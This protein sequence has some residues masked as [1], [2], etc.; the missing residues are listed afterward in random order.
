M[1]LGHDLLEPTVDTRA[2]REALSLVGAGYEVTVFCWARRDD[3]L[4][5]EELRDGVR[6]RRI[7]AALNGWLPG[8]M[9]AFRS[10]MRQ[11]AEAAADELP[12]VVH[13]HD[14]ETLPAACRAA[15]ACG[16]KVV[17]DAHED[18]PLLERVQGAALGAWFGW[19]Q[20]RWLPR[21]D[22]VVTVSPELAKR[23]GG[24]EV[25]YNSEPL[26][27]I[28]A[29]AGEDL[30]ATLGLGGVVAGYIGALRRRII[31]QLLDAAA[32]VPEVTLLVVGGPPKGRAGYAGLQ[33]QLETYAAA[34]GAKAVFTG[35][36]GYGRMG[37]CY[38]A[39]D[40]LLVGHY[41]AEP[42]RHAAV[43]KKLL[44]AMAYAVPAVVGPYD[45]RRVI[46]ER[47]RCGIVAKDWVAP[48]LKLAGDANLRRKMGASG[49]AAWRS[50]YCWDRMEERL[51][52]LYARMLAAPGVP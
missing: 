51:L 30:R 11:L 13:A 14:L 3:S 37:D 15:D 19:Q 5:A 17:F 39:C 52:T 49:H 27:A 8:R 45:A 16:A 23:L 9:L 41:V 36:L 42:L 44:D 26:A 35:P 34:A 38:R 25:L 28:E 40:L 12:A 7:F 50:E 43:P 21:A 29:P 33:E 24:A 22:T 46:V 47:H 10:A 4:P 6:V 20:R 31:E 2:W 48:L 1:L 32:Q 18:W